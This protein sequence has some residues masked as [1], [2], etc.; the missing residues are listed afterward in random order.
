MSYR[1]PATSCQQ[2][3]FFLSPRPEDGGTR[4]SG[5]DDAG[6]LPTTEYGVPTTSRGAGGAA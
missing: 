1:L 4:R 6:G 5:S 3:P 2:D